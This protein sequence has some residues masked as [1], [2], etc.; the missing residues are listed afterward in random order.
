M[1][2]FSDFQD[3][4]LRQP[5]APAVVTLDG[6]VTYSAVL[7]LAE[8]TAGGLLKAG[9]RQG[10]R[11]A[12]QI[13]NRFEL[14]SAYYACL[15]AGAV[16]VPVSYRLSAMEEG[17]L[18]SHSAARFYLGDATLYGPRADMVE[19]S[20]TVEQAWVLDLPAATTG[21]RPWIDLLCD[22]ALAPCDVGPQDFATI[23]YTSGTTGQPKGIVCSDATLQ[24]SLK[25]M[26]ATGCGHAD[27]TYPVYDLINPWCILMLFSCL[28]RGRPLAVTTTHTPDVVLRLMRT[29]PCGWVG[30]PLSLYRGMVEAV[31]RSPEL[32]PDLTNTFCVGGG[33]ACPPDLSRAFFETFGTHLQSTYGQTE[34]AGP[35]VRQPA[36]DSVDEP[37]I[38]WPLPGVETKIDARPGEAGELLLRTPS[39]PVGIWNGTGV[40]RFDPEEWI[41]TGDIVQE[42]PDDC[43]LFLGRQRD[44]IKVDGYGVSPLEVE[45]LLVEHLDVAAVVVFGVPDAVKGERVVAMVEP[46]PGRHVNEAGLL[47]HL[48]GRLAEYKFPSE[49][50]FVDKLPLLPNG[51]LGRQRL[52]TDYTSSHT[53]SPTG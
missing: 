48:S 51:K 42:R 13:G 32:A 10:D 12:V 17:H 2:I 53:S 29:H 15:G 21:A 16:I 22:D 6:G 38:G 45:Q 44:L 27:A 52:A 25:F 28:R 41:A 8:R 5:D 24:A 30:G 19:R 3:V 1:S 23:F 33:D 18:L 39:R 43:L 50:N 31:T 40:D 36:L 14:I 11:V 46:E 9:L 7:S 37:S 26:E 34:T 47:M 4:A 20:D 35:V 49:F